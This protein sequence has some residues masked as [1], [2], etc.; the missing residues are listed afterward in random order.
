MIARTV[1]V[2][3]FSATQRLTCWSMNARTS[4]WPGLDAGAGGFA[5]VQGDDEL[6]ALAVGDVEDPGFPGVERGHGGLARGRF[7][8]SRLSAGGQGGWASVRGYTLRT[9][10]FPVGD[11]PTFVE[12]S[13]SGD[14]RR[15][16]DAG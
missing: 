7:I 5:V 4:G 13:T 1:R 12:S 8:L 11:L 14:C 2:C 16:H 9:L 6:G 15:W 10:A 3:L